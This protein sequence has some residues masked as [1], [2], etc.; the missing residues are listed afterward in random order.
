MI[1]GAAVWS[2]PATGVIAGC[3]G[4]TRWGGVA[5]RVAAS[6]WCITGGVAV[7]AAASGWS[8]TVGGASRLCGSRFAGSA[9]CATRPRPTFTARPR[10]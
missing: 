6:G 1:V 8:I 3:R 4:S 5:V 7:R 2:V 10:S 9:I